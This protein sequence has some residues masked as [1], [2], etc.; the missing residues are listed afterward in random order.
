MA[1]LDYREAKPIYEQVKAE[2]RH[3]VQIGALQGKEKMPSAGVLGAKLAINSGTIAKAYRELEQEG[4]LYSVAGQGLFVAPE[5]ELLKYR[6]HELWNMFEETAQKLMALSVPSEELQAHITEIAA[7][8]NKR[9]CRYW[10][11]E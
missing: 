3:L 10:G 7:E 6:R 9:D 2:I 4:Y 5:E 11:K 1:Q 8:F